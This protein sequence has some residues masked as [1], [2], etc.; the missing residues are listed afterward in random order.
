MGGLSPPS[1]LVPNPLNWSPNTVFYRYLSIGHSNKKKSPFIFEFCLWEDPP[2]PVNWSPTHSTGP[3]TIH[4]VPK[5]FNW[6]PNHSTGPQPI[7]LVPKNCFLQI[8]QYRSLKT[9]PLKKQRPFIFAFCFWKDPP[10]PV[11]W[12]PNHSTGPQNCFLQISQY[13]F[14]KYF[15]KFYWS[16]NCFLQISQYIF[17]KYFPK[18][19]FPKVYF[20][21]VYTQ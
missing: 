20:L 1:Q 7:Q 17:L 12:S 2:H 21:K 11:N 13:I 14:Q 16:Q 19:Y 5:P 4:L 9:T 10:H 8:S 6:S 3:Q 18:F 15:P